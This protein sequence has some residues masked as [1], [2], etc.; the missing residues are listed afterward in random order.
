[1]GKLKPIPFTV[2]VNELP[3]ISKIETNKLFDKGYIHSSQSAID[4]FHGK[5]TE[6]FTLVKDSKDLPSVL[7]NLLL[8]GI[9]SAVESYMRELLRRLVVSDEYTCK[10]CERLPLSYGAAITHQ[11]E[12]LPESLLESYSF[13]SKTNIVEAIR[14]VL[15]YKGNVPDEVGQ[16]LSD[17]T[18]VCQMRHCMVHRYGYLGSNNAI[19]LGL[20]DHGDLF[21]KPLCID[22]DSLQQIFL[23]CVNTVKVLNAF[24]FKF[25]VTRSAT[26][27]EWTWVYKKDKKILSKFLGIFESKLHPPPHE[28]NHKEIFISLKKHIDS[29]K[30]TT[31]KEVAEG[32]LV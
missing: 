11:P 20:D 21:E 24:L 13:A 14:N 2:V 7:G 15:G 17:F 4:T 1:M 31:K 32:D 10:C 16:A 12:M 8:L 28:V 3:S 5:A 25:I 27:D 19:Q 18:T 26:G 23:I 9:V 22:F 30:V 29:A 6:L